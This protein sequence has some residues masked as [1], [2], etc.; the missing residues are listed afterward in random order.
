MNVAVD[1][2]TVQEPQ[3]NFC[4]GLRMRPV[5]QERGDLQRLGAARISQV[6]AS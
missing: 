1:A 3:G 2:T 6:N 4:S 5:P